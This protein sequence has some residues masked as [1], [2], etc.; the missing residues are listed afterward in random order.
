MRATDDHNRAAMAKRPDRVAVL[1]HSGD[2][3]RLHQGLSI[4]AAAVSSSRETSIFFFWWALDR[5][6]RGD[7]A[8]ADFGPGRGELGERFR[9]GRFPTAAELL[10]SARAGGAKVYA[11]TGSMA[12]LGHRPTALEGKVDGFV[13]WTTILNMTSGV[14][15]RFYL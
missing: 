2:Y 14:A 8:T 4:A 7:L 3:D 10:E 11:C 9:D 5:L 12:I 1:L 15:D 6:A 13:G